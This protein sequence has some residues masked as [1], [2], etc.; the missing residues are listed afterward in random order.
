MTD[1]AGGTPGR[2]SAPG[3]VTDT[4]PGS[5]DGGRHCARCGASVRWR[6]TKFCLDRRSRFGGRV[7]CLACQSTFPAV[8]A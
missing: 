3:P 4:P 8:E 6:E 1:R 7:Y 5:A 2:Q